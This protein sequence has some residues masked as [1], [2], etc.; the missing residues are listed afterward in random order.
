[1]EFNLKNRINSQKEILEIVNNHNWNEE[2]YGL[3]HDAIDR[4]GTTNKVDKDIIKTIIEISEEL[5]FLGVQS[6]EQITE[7]Y[8]ELC[9]NIEIKKKKLSYLLNKKTIA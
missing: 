8:F 4:W 9:E 7:D 2:L 1:M 6:Q 5:F 3:S